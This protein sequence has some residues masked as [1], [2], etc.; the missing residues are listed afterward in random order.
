MDFVAMLM[1]ESY[2]SVMCTN[3]Y[4]ECV[5]QNYC[6][7]FGKNSSKNSNGSKSEK[8]SKKKEVQ[9]Q[10]DRK[11]NAKKGD[12]DIRLLQKYIQTSNFIVRD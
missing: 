9:G 8:K 2:T 7:E 5:Y 12:S 6:S 4:P 3:L 1:R 11:T 10:I